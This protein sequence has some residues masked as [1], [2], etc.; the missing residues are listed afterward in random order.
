[1][2]FLRRCME[3]AGLAEPAPMSYPPALRSHLLRRLQLASAG[4]VAGRWF[5][6][7]VATKL[8]AGFVLDTRAGDADRS[9]WEHAQ[10]AALRA[11]P[12]ATPVWLSEPVRFLSEWRY[13]VQDGQII[14]HARYDPE[15]A[16]DAPQPDL[17][18]A[19]ACIAALACPHP[20]VLDLGVLQDGRTALVE[21]NDA[22]AIGLY[23]KAMTPAAYLN[24]LWQRWRLLVP[25]AAA[26]SCPS[27]GVSRSTL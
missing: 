18:V 10:L 11:L 14:G 8:F 1:V 24:F 4:V 15:G 5:V 7:P 21:T 16:Q 6:K 17:R 12:P 26:P 3:R 23:P 27:A 20:W 19:H 13:Y 25:I 2:A 22:W 9:A